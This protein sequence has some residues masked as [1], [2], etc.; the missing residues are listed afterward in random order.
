[1]RFFKTLFIGFALLIN[2]LSAAWIMVVLGSSS[3]LGDTLFI[4]DTDGYVAFG[5][6]A[7]SF[8]ASVLLLIAL[9]R[10]RSYRKSV[11]QRSAFGAFAAPSSSY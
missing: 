7:A 2:F 8:L 6:A 4:S 11:D 1:M 9:I 5:L 10:R 3:V